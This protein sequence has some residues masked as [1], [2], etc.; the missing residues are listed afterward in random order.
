M[1]RLEKQ[2]H[3]LHDKAITR[4][5]LKEEKNVKAGGF[6]ISSVTKGSGINFVSEELTALSEEYAEV[7]QTYN[8]IQEQMISEVLEVAQE[9]ITKLQKMN[10]VLSVIDVLVALSV[11]S[12]NSCN[13]YVRPHLEEKGT[14]IFELIQCRH[15]VIEEKND[16]QY[17]A[18]DVNL[19]YK[20]TNGK[21]TGPRFAV[22]T[23]ANMGGKSTYLR[24]AGLTVILAQMGC[25]V[26]CDSAHFSVFDGIHTRVGA[27]DFQCNGVSTFMAEMVDCV[28]IL[29]AAKS[30]SLV[31]VDELGRGTSTYDGFGMAWG[32]AN[33][34]LNK[35]GA[36]C[37]FAT[38]YH[39]ISVLKERYPDDVVNLKVETHVD[40]NGDI[41]L[42]YKIVEGL[43]ERSFGIN[44][45]QCVN[46]PDHIIK[47]FKLS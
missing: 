33:H 25:F 13:S 14:G 21:I 19:H 41:A 35:I 40:E 12:G 37:L 6:T 46:F 9:N 29:D 42:L 26:P 10:D 27:S 32:V 36:F 45:A 30:T 18:N 44:I 5:V 7:S 24:A 34:I 22:V 23:G 38:H 47:N 15:P 39:E 43:A 28:A 17:I 1:E 3:K 20:Q 11:V 4:T 31:L 16:I 8:Q 2:A